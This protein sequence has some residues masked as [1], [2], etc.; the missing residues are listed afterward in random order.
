MTRARP[1]ETL[2]AALAVVVGSWPLTTL[3]QQTQWLVPA[4]LFIAAVAGLGV[5]GRS[6]GLPGWSILLGQSVL[7]AA[8]LVAFYLN[9]HLWFGLPSTGTIGEIADRTR[10]TIHIATTYA[11]PAPGTPGVLLVIIAGMAAVAVAVDYIGITRSSPA[12]A[13]LPLL[14]EFLVSASNSGAALPWYFFL[15][16]A[17]MWLLMLARDGSGILR[18]WPSVQV[19][20]Q[21]PVVAETD[22]RSVMG[23]A[24]VAR[25]VGLVALSLALVLPAVIP[26]LPPHY[27]EPGLGRNANAVGTSSVA[28]GDTVDLLADLGDRSPRAILRYTTTDFDPPP[29]R[30]TVLTNYVD[31][32][33]QSVDPATLGISVRTGN[34]VR[35]PLTGVR[36]NVPRHTYTTRVLS[37]LLRSPEVATPALL[38]AGGFGSTAWGLDKPTGI[39]VVSHTP[40]RYDV[41]YVHVAPDGIIPSLPAQTTSGLPQAAYDARTLDPAS[42]AMVSSLTAQVTR[43]DSNSLQE[44]TDIQDYLR[45]PAR[46]TYSLKLAPRQRDSRGD[47]LDPISNFLATRRGYCVQFAT[48][49][50]MM[51]RAAGIPARM[52]EGFLPGTPNDQNVYTVVAADAH[53]WPELW[54]T[55][56]GWTRFEPTPAIQSGEAP[57]YSTTAP[58]QVNGGG[59]PLQGANGSAPSRT[60]RIN[61]NPNAPLGAVPATG[62]SNRHLQVPSQ[63]PMGVGILVLA[64]LALLVLPVSARLS[65]RRRLRRAATPADRVDAQ[66]TSMVSQLVDL[67]VPSPSGRTPRQLRTYYARE[68]LL[69][70]ETLPALAR[71]AAEL[72]RTRYAVPSAVQ[73][74]ADISSEVRQVI[75]AVRRS[76]HRLARLRAFLIPGDGRSALRGMSEALSAQLRRPAAWLER[77]R[78]SLGS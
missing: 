70:R 1:V 48:A 33:W 47:Y 53:A 8:L 49:M 68:A 37:N 30:V 78:P 17:T 64:G 25:S 21:T 28:F 9:D 26:H 5:L 69:D 12:L 46:F 77:R 29:L 11:A 50:V 72:E 56:L 55:G 36:A 19:N 18:R 66:W 22:D 60:P 59:H 4:V 34:Q 15:A 58:G 27:L 42:E 23:Y 35:D 39:A 63:W 67:G 44:A 13:G 24:T 41:S 52:A 74:S 76:R 65:R 61:T 7:V 20:P 6:R 62:A 2:I 43:G 16:L 3:V 71:A 45:D 10:D 14:G 38:V 73:G 40:S 31:G 54:I 57:Q 32:K 51:A 75:T